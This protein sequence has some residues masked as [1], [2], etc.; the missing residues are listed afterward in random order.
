MAPVEKERVVSIIWEIV[1][2]VNYLD[3]GCGPARMFFKKT[4]MGITKRNGQI[5]RGCTEKKTGV[6]R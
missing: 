6:S 1:G 5:I 3:S 4:E 2:E